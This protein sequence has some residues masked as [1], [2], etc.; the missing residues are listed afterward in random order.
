MK[1]WAR[2]SA[3]SRAGESTGS[4]ALPNSACTDLGARSALAAKSRGDAHVKVLSGG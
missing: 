1:P 3:L 2:R 4:G